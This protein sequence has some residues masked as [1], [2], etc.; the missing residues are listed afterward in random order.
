[1]TIAIHSVGMPTT[2]GVPQWVHLIPAGSFKGVDGRGPFTLLDPPSVIAASLLNGP[3][4]IDINHS[5]D[6]A[7]PKGDPSPA[8]G[9]VGRMEARADGIW[10]MVEWTG[11]GRQMVANREY[12]FISPVFQHT[13]KMAVLKIL[14]G[15]ITNN[16]NLTE[17]AALNHAIA[18]HGQAVASPLG[19]TEDDRK[20]CRMMNLR[21]EDFLRTKN[22]IAGKDAYDNFSDDELSILRWLSMKPDQFIARAASVPT[23]SDVWFEVLPAT[24]KTLYRSEL[25]RP[26]QDTPKARREFALAHL[27][28]VSSGG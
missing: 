12:R 16:P 9:W 13:S 1:M 3:L 27:R 4:P 8:V 5:T 14:R 21:E 28:R 19:L 18:L 23:G 22:G 20:V 11:S 24:A 17:L 2:G 6:L 10:G 15:A 26:S 25:Y 7:A